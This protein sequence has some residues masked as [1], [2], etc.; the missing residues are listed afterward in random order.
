MPEG[1]TIFRTAAVLDAALRG[2][3]VSA[4]RARA[5]ARL[6]HPPELSRLVGATV[7]GVRPLGKHL[8][9][10]F[11]LGL[12]LRTHLGMHG[13]WHRYAPG[14]PW[15]RPATQATVVIETPGAV[16]V[17]FNPP[18]V[19]LLTDAEAARHS[20]LGSLGPDLL[21]RSIDTDLAI[22]RL[23][24]RN[25]VELGEALLDQRA[26]S[27]I[28]NVYKSEVCFVERV[29]PWFRVAAADDA[30][31][32]RLLVTARRLLRAN[33]R[34]GARVTTGARGTPLWVY[35]RR[36]RPCRRCGTRVEGRRQGS[37]ARMTYWCPRCQP[38]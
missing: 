35:G 36:G 21:A 28:G 4:A 24:K 26:V 3:R 10:G 17:C 29:S 33:V 2:Q 1:D 7:T 27:G 15:R 37:A 19:E 31:L 13:S 23:R 6:S 18:E 12:V 25:G 34:G 38:G 16:A 11:D 30:T 22:A 9:I 8:L 5:H 20:T 14:E 32:T